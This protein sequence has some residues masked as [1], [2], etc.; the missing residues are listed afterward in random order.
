LDKFEGSSR[1]ITHHLAGSLEPVGESSKGLPASGVLVICAFKQSVVKMKI[2]KNNF[3]MPSFF[4]V[5]NGGS[6]ISWA[7]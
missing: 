3:F 6:M 7:F 2:M 4:M 5:F 1:S